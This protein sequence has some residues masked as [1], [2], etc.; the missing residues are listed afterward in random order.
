M[1]DVP[2]GKTIAKHAMRYDKTELFN[3]T[4]PGSMEREAK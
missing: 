4:T 2:Q 3:G 1:K